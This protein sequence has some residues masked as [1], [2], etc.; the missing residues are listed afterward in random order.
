MGLSFQ[1]WNRWVDTINQTGCSI[2]LQEAPWPSLRWKPHPSCG[3]QSSHFQRKHWS[4][5]RSWGHRWEVCCW[6]PPPSFSSPT[7]GGAIF[8]LSPVCWLLRG[9][10][11]S[12]CGILCLNSVNIKVG[13]L[14]V[15]CLVGLTPPQRPI[16][17]SSGP[18]VHPDTG[19]VCLADVELVSLCHFSKEIQKI[20]KKQNSNALLNNHH[21]TISFNFWQYHSPIFQNTK[22]VKL[23]E[24][25]PCY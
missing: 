11:C 20:I 5:F 13:L 7:I 21:P 2:F 4:W 8:R 16:G 18:M 6:V 9:R 14:I 23:L 3:S 25:C 12:H 10:F 15:L 17:L 19:L 1:N 24:A 22:E